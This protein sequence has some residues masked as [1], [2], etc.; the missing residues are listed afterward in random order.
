MSLPKQELR[1]DYTS[2]TLEFIAPEG[3]PSSVTIKVWEDSASDEDTE[4]T[5]FGAASVESVSTTFDASSGASQSDRKKMNLTA[6]TS[7]VVNNAPGRYLITNAYGQTERP[8][9]DK[10]ESGVAAWSRTPLAYDY[11]AADTF[12]SC[13]VTF[14]VDST[15]IADEDNISDPLCPNP[16]WRAA[17]TYTANS[18]QYRT[19]ILFD[20]VR[21]PFVTS[22]TAMDVERGSQGWLGRVSRNDPSG[23]WT[24]DEAV[25]QVKLDLWER[26]VTAY[27]LRNSP[28][29]NELVRLKAI[30]IV[31]EHAMAHGGIGEAQVRMSTTA[32]WDRLQNLVASSVAAQQVTPDGNAGQVKRRPL[33]VR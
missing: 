32:Y 22:V 30:Q 12:V 5:A 25:H 11:A 15:W 21:Y 7:L 23:Q 27:A 1:F 20:V 26:K 28:V 14:P 18:V 4:E 16:R 19:A 10:I 8:V 3:R 29:L 24:I 17:I 2:G 13:L 33:S 6:T 9:I 31:H